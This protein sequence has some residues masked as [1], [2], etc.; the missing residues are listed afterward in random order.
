LSVTD[1][2]LSRTVSFLSG[3]GTGIEEFLVDL[4]LG[5]TAFGSIFYDLTLT[6]EAFSESFFYNT[7]SSFF[8]SL[9]F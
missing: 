5:T 6:F 7:T 2:F 8:G 1:S 3:T 4:G 9:T